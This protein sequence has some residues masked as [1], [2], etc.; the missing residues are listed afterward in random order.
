MAAQKPHATGRVKAGDLTQRV[1]VEQMR[2]RGIDIDDLLTKLVAA[3]G[4][5]FTTYYYYTILRMQLAGHEGYKELF[6]QRRNVFLIA[7]WN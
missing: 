1:G 7:P 3:A 5:E 4:A 6:R 2:D